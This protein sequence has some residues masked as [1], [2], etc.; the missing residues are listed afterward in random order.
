MQK[1]P[2]L[3]IR[4]GTR[5]QPE[6]SRSAILHA[7]LAEFAQEGLA[8][9]RMDAIAEAAGVNKALLYY[10][11][12]DKDTLYGAILDSFFAPMHD[13]VLAVCEQPGSAGERFLAYA[14]VH[15]D[16]IAESPHYAH[17]FMGELMSAGR[18]G[19]THL[20]RIAEKYMM[21]VGLAV[22]RLLEEGVRSGEFR[23]VDPAQFI[24]SAIGS[25]VHY[26]L[27]APLRKKFAQVTPFSEQSLSARR[28]AVLDF[29]AAALFADRDAG[30]RMAAKTAQDDQA[31]EQHRLQQLRP[32]ALKRGR[33]IVVEGPAIS[34]AETTRNISEVEEAGRAR[35]KAK[36]SK[37]HGDSGG[38]K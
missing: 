19:S 15:F 14:R 8:G 3:K 25:I 20:D 31:A 10:Y 22:L 5:R 29:I 1:S 32:S 34:D 9:A 37:D 11:F 12:S 35:R 33:R 17:I 16:S 23:P 30:T 28:A 36:R 4:R 24:P 18:G 27:T 21:P 26:F 13:R 38:P 2:Y 6:R 7:A